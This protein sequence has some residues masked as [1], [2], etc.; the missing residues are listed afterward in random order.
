MAH[1]FVQRFG[2]AL[3]MR[4]GSTITLPAGLFGQSIIDGVETFCF[5]A[6][7]CTQESDRVLFLLLDVLLL[8]PPDEYPQA[9]DEVLERRV[10]RDEA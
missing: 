7:Q 5:V 4:E 1:G 9:E 6:Q 8:L 2:I 10:E 3:P